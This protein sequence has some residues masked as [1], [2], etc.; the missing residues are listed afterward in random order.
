MKLLILV[1]LFTG[2]AHAGLKSPFPSTV[3]QLTINNSHKVDDKL[4]RGMA[5][6]GK[7]QELIDFG[8]TDILIFKNQTRNEV[9]Q[10][11]EE[12]S[13]KG[14][15]FSVRQIDFLWHDYPSYKMACEQAIVALRYMRE[16]NEQPGRK[17]FFHCTVG[18]DRTG[19]LAGLW[20]MLAQG[21]SK[22]KAFY[23]E[24]CENGYANGNPQKPDYVVGEIREDLSPLY[25]YMANQIEL[26]NLSLGDLDPSICKD[27]LADDKIMYCRSSSRYPQQ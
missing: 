15:G 25:M 11:L 20:R 21:W 23:R 26:G 14:G 10:Q 6:L 9:D 8:V 1:F 24:M 27:D 7:V 22:R 18:E 12:I 3:E 4:Y 2:F 5:P 19:F 13:D 16:V 17:L